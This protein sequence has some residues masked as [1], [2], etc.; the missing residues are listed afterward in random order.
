MFPSRY[1]PNR[2]FPSR[3]F[4][5]VGAG[6]TAFIPDFYFEHSTNI[7]I[8]KAP[9]AS[10][11]ATNTV[12]LKVKDFSYNQSSRTVGVSRDTLNPTQE[13]TPTPHI[14]AINPVTF[15]FVTYVLPLVDTNVTSPEEYLWTSLMGADTI[16]GSP[17]STP[18]S[19]TIDFADGNVA[20]LQ[21]LTIW[22]DQPLQT[23]GNYRL[24]NCIVDSADFKFDINGI[25]EI[26]WSGRA[27]SITEFNTLPSS[28]NRTTV[29]N[30]IKNK[31][32][33]ITLNMNSINYTVA[34]TGGNI[35]FDNK[36]TFYS[37]NKLG[38]TTVPV[39]HYTG[40]REVK[41]TLDFYM[42]SGTN[43]TV[44][45]FNAL[46]NNITNTDYETTHEA[47]ITIDI[48]GAT[49]TPRIRFTLPQA[50]LELPRQNFGGLYKISVPFRAK[51]QTGSYNTVI[52]TA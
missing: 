19:S 37:R 2:Y 28:T 35:R 18:T 14:S 10:A 52:Y 27:L 12:R 44:E 33:T 43:K 3:Y 47:L 48:G 30:Y 22:F 11:N 38:Q 45:L 39:G 15:T 21:N 50:L 7:Y 9:N 46:L 6:A 17:N 29:T 32:S 23:Q 31:P 16:E 8:S 41:G 40:N 34:L 1:F 4:A 51:E 25:A 24:D 42:K 5:N 26:S 49:S 13:R 36:N 20:E